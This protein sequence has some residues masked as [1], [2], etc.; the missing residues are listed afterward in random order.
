MHRFLQPDAIFINGKLTRNCVAVLDGIGG[1]CIEEASQVKPEKIERFENECWTEAPILAHAHLESYDAPSAEWPRKSFSE[2]VGSL[3]EWRAST[4]RLSPEES[5]SASL[6]ELRNYGCGGVLSHVSEVSA[7]SSLHEECKALPMLWAL[8]EVFEP[9]G[10]LSSDK[11]AELQTNPA[12][13]L[14]SPFGVSLEVASS[15]FSSH[16]LVSIHL[17]EHQ[18]EREFLAHASGPLAALF[19]ERSRMLPPQRFTSPVDWLEA[20]GGLREGV[21]AVHASELKKGE[22][23]RLL[24]AGV[25]VVWCPGTHNYFERPEPIFSLVMKEPPLLG[26]DSRASNE[27]LDPM[28][29]FRLACS[30]CPGFSPLEWWKSLTTRAQGTLD[31]QR[32]AHLP[33]LR[34]ELGDTELSPTGTGFCEWLAGPD[35]PLHGKLLPLS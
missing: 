16:D 15:L 35:A 6:E 27:S 9:T 31:P 23:N 3:L 17:G 4:N 25:K 11:M 19:E 21:L 22:L 18:E 20:A 5:A 34:W 2:W 26:C 24:G 28:R 1:L 14:H 32:K 10:K 33:L 12:V 29:E 30:E 7:R 8:S 13:A